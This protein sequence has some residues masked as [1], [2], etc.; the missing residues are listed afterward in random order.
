[1]DRELTATGYIPYT[2]HRQNIEFLGLDDIGHHVFRCVL[3]WEYFV[4]IMVTCRDQ[5]LR[6]KV[7][8]V[9][10][11]SNFETKDMKFYFPYIA[12]TLHGKII[13]ATVYNGCSV[14]FYIDAISQMLHRLLPVLPHLQC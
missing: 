7:L 11:S 3:Q 5:S 1:M 9:I 8:N 14:Q 2:H 10:F 6:C 13:A 4:E 12:I